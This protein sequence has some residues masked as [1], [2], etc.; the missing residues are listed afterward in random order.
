MSY[1]AELE[2]YKQHLMQAFHEK[3]DIWCEH[4]FLTWHWWIITLVFIVTILLWIFTFRRESIHRALYVGAFVAV[5]TSFLD[6][7]G[8]FFHLWEYRYDLIPFANNFLPWNFIVMPYF[9]VLFLK[10]MPH[11]NR[12]LKSFLYGIFSS[13]I[14]LPLLKGLG[15][16]QL[17]H[18]HYIFSFCVQFCIFLFAATLSKGTRFERF[19]EEN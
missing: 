16:Y 8:I 2:H 1:S 4:V 3:Y 7:I 15:Y 5:T 12:F 13:F 14:A 19:G 6:S 17:V 11:M 18:W 10:I 9:V